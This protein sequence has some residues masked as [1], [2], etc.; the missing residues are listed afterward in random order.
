[1][2]IP[3][4]GYPLAAAVTPR[5]HVVEMVDST[6]AKLVRDATDDPDGHPH[7]SAVLTRDQRAGRGRL[8]RSWTA[9]PG[10]AIAVSVL[11]D[12]AAIADADR[13]WIPLLAGAA[14]QRAVAAQ[15]TDLDVSLKWPNDIVRGGGK[16]GGILCE[17]RARGPLTRLVV[18]CGLNLLPPP[19]AE[20]VVVAQPVAGLFEEGG[21]PDVLQ[22]ARRLGEAIL[23]ATDRL[24]ADGLAPFLSQWQE[25]DLLRDRPIVIHHHDGERQAIARGVDVDGALLVEPS[26]RPGTRERLLAEE[27]SVRPL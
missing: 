1:M 20:A 22:L 5:L 12:V 14:M 8:D 19:D 27:V 9:P 18:G 17:A 24:L 23:A 3:A 11:L 26:D 4:D 15:L 16:A 25:H 6:N 10:T 2:S 13:G 7:L 21:V